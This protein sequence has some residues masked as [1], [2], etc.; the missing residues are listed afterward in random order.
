LSNIGFNTRLTTYDCGL[1]SSWWDA[2]TS[3]SDK[4]GI[5]GESNP[6]ETTGTFSFPLQDLL[7]G[8]PEAL[9]DLQRHYGHP[10]AALVQRGTSFFTTLL[11]NNYNYNN[12]QHIINRKT[13]NHN[14]QP[15][16]YKK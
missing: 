16:F 9:L 11:Y 1:Y 5:S 7:E 10:L 4:K 2:L 15:P 12:T 13:R 8:K 6:D 3:A 14:N